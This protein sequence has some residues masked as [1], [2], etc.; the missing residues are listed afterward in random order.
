M[1]KFG[2]S[3]DIL[4]VR[5]P[6]RGT[7]LIERRFVM[8][9]KIMLGIIAV[10]A[11]LCILGCPDGDKKDDGK[12]GKSPVTLT[13]TIGSNSLSIT[14]VPADV[15]GTIMAATLMGD[16]LLTAGQNAVPAAVGMNISG[17]FSFLS[18]TPPMTLGDPFTTLGEYHIVLATSMGGTPPNYI[19]VEPVPQ[20]PT[21]KMP[22]KYNFAQPTGT[23]AWDDKFVDQSTLGQP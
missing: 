20:A 13:L 21:T 9:K 16:D 6:I 12:K 3:V 4:E 10:I 23:L 19:Y 7:K 18:F 17:T 15:A 11:V 1:L 22:A 14:G 8:K 5:F 2:K